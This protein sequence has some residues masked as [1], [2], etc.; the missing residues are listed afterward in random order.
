MATSAFPHSKLCFAE[1]DGPVHKYLD[2]CPE[3]SSGSVKAIATRSLITDAW[4][5]VPKT[6]RPESQLLVTAMRV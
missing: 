6:C 2:Q 1:D 3:P 4:Y 5:F